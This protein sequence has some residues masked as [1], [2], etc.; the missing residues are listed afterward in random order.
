MSSTKS[1]KVVG[2]PGALCERARSWHCV[3]GLEI[4]SDQTLT[5]FLI[6]KIYEFERIVA[7]VDF[8]K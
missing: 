5:S 3:K 7:L 4:G 2:V 8:Q 1:D 6:L